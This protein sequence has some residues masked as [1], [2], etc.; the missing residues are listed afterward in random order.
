MD[1]QKSNMNKNELKV[2]SITFAYPESSITNKIYKTV[3]YHNI[4]NK[5]SIMVVVGSLLLQ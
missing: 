5:I 1:K 3:L 2:C 4:K